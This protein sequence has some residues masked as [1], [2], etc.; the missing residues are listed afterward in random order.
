MRT[1]DLQRKWDLT[2]AE[3]EA[4][5]EKHSGTFGARTG[6]TFTRG[7]GKLI[8][9]PT[10]EW[11][12]VPNIVTNQGLDTILDVMFSGG[13]QIA[14]ANW[15]VIA[16]KSDTTPAAGTTYATPVFTEITGSDVSET[17]RE[18]WTDGGVS[19]QSVDN[20]GAVATYTA[21]GALTLY[22]A[23]IAGAPSAAPTTF[24]DTAA[25][26]AIIYAAA[27]FATSKV[28]A[29]SDT[30]DITYTLNAADDGV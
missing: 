16:F 10:S 23:A 20:S 26:N 27:K 18:A 15:V 29:S 22:G 28:L 2:A 5:R 3:V 12:T 25:S 11:E 14:A 24:G 21:A 8:W 4:I 19:S 17:V 1:I 7:R 13:S 9:E 30:I 6:R